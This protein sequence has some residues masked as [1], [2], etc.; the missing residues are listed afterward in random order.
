[1]KAGLV[2]ETIKSIKQTAIDKQ[3]YELAS[4]LREIERE[5][6][7]FLVFCKNDTYTYEDEVQV[8]HFTVLLQ[9]CLIGLPDDQ[10][11]LLTP[12][13]RELKLSQLL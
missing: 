13:I 2:I 12:I 7:Q 1:M 10:R 4:N 11:L 9:S 3:M 5:L 8:S 6:C